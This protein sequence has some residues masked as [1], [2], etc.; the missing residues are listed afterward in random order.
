MKT[1]TPPKPPGDASCVAGFKERE[2]SGWLQGTLALKAFLFNHS[3]NFG[4]WVLSYLKYL[5]SN[6]AG[7]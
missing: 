1:H 4:R 3:N 2:Q 5:I 6:R 7:H